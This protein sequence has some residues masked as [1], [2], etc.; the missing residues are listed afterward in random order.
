MLFS[1]NLSFVSLIYRLL[2]SEPKEGGRKHFFFPLLWWH[3]LEWHNLIFKTK[4]VY[5]ETVAFIVPITIYQ[6]GVW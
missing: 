4:N 1:V 2:A 5:I 3:I 6:C